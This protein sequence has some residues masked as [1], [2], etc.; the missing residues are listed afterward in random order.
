MDPLLIETR[1]QAEAAVAQITAL[2]LQLNDETNQQNAKLILAR[3]HDQAIKALEERRA[4]YEEAV[5]A[6]A[7]RNRKSLRLDGQPGEKK[8]IEL[9]QGKIGFRWGPRKVSLLKGFTE[10]VV[11][12]RLRGLAKK[13]KHWARY[14]RVAEALNRSQVLD[15][16]RPEAGLLSGKDLTRIGLEV[17]REESFYV[18]PKLEPVPA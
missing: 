9:R 8:S 16:A 7:R 17:L 2:T 5:E 11:L 12:A 6:W 14:I 18:E 13:A 1:D 3:K 4:R 15:D 10:E